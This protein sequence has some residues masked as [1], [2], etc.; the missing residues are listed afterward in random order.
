MAEAVWAMLGRPYTADPEKGPFTVSTVKI[1]AEVWERLGWLS[2][3]T[4][5]AKQDILADAL[6]DHFAKVVKGR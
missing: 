3:W 6:K 4:G 1:P 2:K 5:R